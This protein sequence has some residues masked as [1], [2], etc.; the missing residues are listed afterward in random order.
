MA[1]NSRFAVATHIMLSVA[2]KKSGEL[3]SSA[4]LSS[5]VNTNP[6]VIRRILSDLQK[7]GLLE[8]EFGRS[9]GAR[10]SKPAGKISMYEIFRAVDAGDVFAFNPNKPKKT[11]TLSCKMKSILEPVFSSAN[12]ALAS[13]LK[14]TLLSDLVKKVE[15][16]I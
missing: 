9:G 5:S 10:L 11:C 3:A 14:E 7:A 15:Q 6:V 12:E 13:N 8:T 4:Y 2:V 1:A 16:T